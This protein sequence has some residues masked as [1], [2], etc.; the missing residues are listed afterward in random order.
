MELLTAHPAAAIVCLYGTG[1]EIINAL[2]VV[3]HSV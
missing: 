3:Q 1:S 2:S